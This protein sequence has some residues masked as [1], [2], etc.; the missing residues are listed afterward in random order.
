MR[1]KLPSHTGKLS[2]S[3]KCDSICRFCS[4]ITTKKQR[5]KTLANNILQNILQSICR[6]QHCTTFCANECMERKKKQE[7]NENSNEDMITTLP[8]TSRGDKQDFHLVHRTNY[9]FHFSH[10]H[11]LQ[12]KRN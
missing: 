6:P 10:T 1:V 3:E 9:P 7:Y 12:N 5:K 4:L 8:W 2:I 11:S